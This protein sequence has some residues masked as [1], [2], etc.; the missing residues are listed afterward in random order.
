MFIDGQDVP[1][2]EEIDEYDGFG[3]LS[4][5]PQSTLHF[6]CVSNEMVVGTGQ[7]GSTVV[8]VCGSFIDFPQFT[9]KLHSWQ[10]D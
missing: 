6:N 3:D 7:S 1:V 8:A 9:V 2:E 4:K 10:G 5:V